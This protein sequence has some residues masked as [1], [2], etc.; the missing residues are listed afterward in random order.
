MESYDIELQEAIKNGNNI[1]IAGHINPD[2]DAVSSALGL[3]LCLKMI[4]KDVTVL[5]ED[6]SHKFHYIKGKEMIYKGDYDKLAPDLFIAVDCGSK[7]RLGDAQS[8]F[9]RTEKTINIDHHISNTEY[10]KYNVVYPNASSSSEVVFEIIRNFSVI[11]DDIATALYTGIVSDTGGFKHN[12]TSPR[13]HEI[14]SVLIGFD[15]PYSEIQNRILYSKSREEL[16]VFIK[17]LGKLKIENGISRITLTKDEIAESGATYKDLDGIVSF[18]LNVDDVDASV[19][20]YEK[21]N[22]KSKVSMRSISTDVSGIAVKHGGGGHKLAAGAD[23]DC[24][25]EEAEKIIVKE[26]EAALSEGV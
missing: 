2:G 22:G 16:S 10:A 23:F 13:T 19:F 3:A 14:A 18:I 21:E 1:C 25:V 8:V 26:L 20:I 7:D 15:V 12:C 5:L 17:A 24:S 4:G 11:T 6:Y 9:D